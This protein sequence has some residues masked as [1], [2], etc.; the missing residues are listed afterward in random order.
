MK[1]TRKEA[2]QIKNK[3]P[4]WWPTAHKYEARRGEGEA[5]YLL[6][7]CLYRSLGPVWGTILAFILTDCEKPWTPLSRKTSLWAEIWTWDLPNIKQTATH[8]TMIFSMYNDT[9]KKTSCPLTSIVT[10][11]RGGWLGNVISFTDRGIH[12]VSLYSV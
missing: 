5:N 8:S 11:P 12:H 1:I 4:I 10:R 7:V 6:P 9:Q 2:I 3:T